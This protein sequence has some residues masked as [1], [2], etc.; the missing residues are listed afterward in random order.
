MLS[1]QSQKPI[2]QR[3]NLNL[4]TSFRKYLINYWRKF[5]ILIVL[6]WCLFVDK[7]RSS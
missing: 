7:Q 5:Q 4:I 1:I 6:R 2:N 3:D